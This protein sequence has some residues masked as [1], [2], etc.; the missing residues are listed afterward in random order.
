MTKGKRTTRKI[1]QVLYAERPMKPGV[2]GLISTMTHFSA[3]QADLFKL[4]FSSSIP[5][6]VVWI[7]YAFVSAVQRLKVG[8]WRKLKQC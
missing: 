5:C 6:N 3:T 7:R 8:R 4:H 2:R 1:S